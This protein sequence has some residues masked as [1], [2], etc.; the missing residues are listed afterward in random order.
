MSERTCKAPL[1][2]HDILFRSSSNSSFEVLI[3]AVN[4]VFATVSVELSLTFLSFQ[5][6]VK[7]QDVFDEVWSMKNVEGI[8]YVSFVEVLIRCISETFFEGIK[9]KLSRKVHRKRRKA[10]DMKLRSILFFKITS[11]ELREHLR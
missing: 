6:Q 10:N 9:D 7:Q 3:K 8:G 5:K 4:K 11:E 2:V 1:T